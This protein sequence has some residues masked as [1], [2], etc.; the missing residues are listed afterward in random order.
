VTEWNSP[1]I[2]SIADA[3]LAFVD[4]PS[5]TRPTPLFWWSGADLSRPRLE[6]E[7]DQLHE[8]GIGGTIVGYSHLPDGRLDHGNPEP[9]SEEWWELFRWFTAASAERG[10][11]TGIQDYGV[12]GTVL[13]SVASQT[14][15]LQAG[16]LSNIVIQLAPGE[17][18]RIGAGEGQVISAIAWPASLSTR[19]SITLDPA[20]FSS[21]V[22]AWNTRTERW[23]LSAVVRTPG[24]I[25]L[26][27]TDFDPMHPRAG[28]AVIE[29]FYA[30]F[31]HELGELFGTSFR[32]F[33]QDELDLGIVMPMWN[34]AVAETVA[35]VFPG[36]DV[37]H[38]LWHDLG[39]P[40]HLPGHCRESSRRQLL[41]PDL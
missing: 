19:E 9:F 26:D 25:G 27:Y 12:I 24:K 34:D 5:E 3:Y 13:K 8:Q 31:N 18:V 41:S 14:S 17:P 2:S 22:P 30:R 21:A 40:G 23:H 20:S 38:A 11:T 39:L 29:A 1:R 10:M 37:V 16:T 35:A 15:G 7:L 33:F 32:T 28:S 6:W 36:P 4:P